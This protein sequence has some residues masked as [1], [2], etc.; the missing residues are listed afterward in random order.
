[1]LINFIKYVYT[2]IKILSDDLITLLTIRYYANFLKFIKE[3]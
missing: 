2:I 1:M 3:T